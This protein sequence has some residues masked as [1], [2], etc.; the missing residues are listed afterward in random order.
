MNLLL[1]K[2]FYRLSGKFF[3]ACVAGERI[4]RD[5]SGLKADSWMNVICL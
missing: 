4:L 3:P 1:N 5:S 2:P